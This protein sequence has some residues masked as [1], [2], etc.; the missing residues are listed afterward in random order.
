MTRQRAGLGVVLGMNARNAHIAR[1]NPERSIRLVD[2]K[3]ATK[4]HLA[5][6]GAPVPP[7]V[8]HVRSARQLRALPAAGLPDAWACKPNRSLGGQGILLVGRRGQQGWTSLSG[9]AVREADVTH[10]VRRILDGEFSP[11]GRDTALFEPLLHPHEDIADLAA[12]GLPDVRVLCDGEDPRMAMLRLPTTRSEGRANLHAGGI[13]AAVD[14]RTGRITGAVTGRRAVRAHPD[15]G[16]QL[17]GRPVPYWHDVL[18]AA[19]R[20]APATGL[21]YLGA[22]IVVDA[23]RGPLI[24]EVNARP[25]LE[26]QNVVRQGLAPVVRW[27]ASPTTATK[28]TTR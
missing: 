11:G 21:R 15:T 6:S 19:A 4:D 3:Q 28:G 2:D 25:G 8:T 22:D 24:L 17:E 20:C 23:E 9:R 7:T 10:H 13:G 27:A 18:D 14:L 12:A 5:A 16:A 1:H 26:I